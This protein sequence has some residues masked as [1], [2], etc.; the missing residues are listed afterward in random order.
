MQ[1]CYGI[2]CLLNIGGVWAGGRPW[3]NLKKS[4]TWTMASREA[5]DA[6]RVLRQAEALVASLS[7]TTLSTASEER[8]R[9]VR[10]PRG[11]T[12]RRLGSPGCSPRD[13]ISI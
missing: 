11:S 12:R 5:V 1:N 4:L 8:L 6:A 9:H 13:L 2:T 3:E 10:T 7:A